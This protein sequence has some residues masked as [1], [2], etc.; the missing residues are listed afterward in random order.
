[1][2][3]CSFSYF[4]RVFTIFTRYVEDQFLKFQFSFVFKKDQL[5]KKK[6]LNI[7]I[8]IQEIISNIYV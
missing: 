8:M 6:Y 5:H 4:H 2:D 1:M 3:Y 7:K